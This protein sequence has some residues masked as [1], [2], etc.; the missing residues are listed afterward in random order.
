MKIGIGLPTTLDI[1]GPSIVAWAQRAE[2]RGFSNL[3]T[4]DRIVYPNYESLTSLGVA[5]GATSQIGLMT[6]ILVS[7]L[8][9]PVWLA[10]ATASLNALSGGRFT[11]G[12]AVGGREDD[13]LAMHRPF[14][15]RGAL[16]DEL[17]DVL[18]RAWNGDPVAG[19]D[20]AVVPAAAVQNRPRLLI[21]GS[22]DIA[23][24][25]VAKYGDGWTVGGAGPLVAYHGA[26][27]AR[28]AWQK[29]GREGEP[30]LV[31]LTYFGLG[32]DAATAQS[33]G[34][35]YAFLGEYADRVVNNAL[36]TAGQIQEAVKAFSDAGFSE[37]IFNPTV[38][39]IDQV[40]RLADVVL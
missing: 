1:D 32:D 12:A 34:K 15:Q 20:L 27:K 26:Q 16:M 18:N 13:F 31:A 25:R 19:S 2:E 24:E 8:Y 38:A 28:G 3:A 23:Y 29:A 9:Q 5:A 4:I 11:L 35:Y 6:N 33:L 7:P 40:D 37:M 17:L 22:V 14:H 10:K 30:D 39:S 21:G 36:V